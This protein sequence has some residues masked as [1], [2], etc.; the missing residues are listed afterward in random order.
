MKSDEYAPG[1]QEWHFAVA[2]ELKEEAKTLSGEDKQ[3]KQELADFH[4]LIGQNQ[5]KVT[6]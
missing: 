1:S 3:Y 4:R 2:D 6:K 5:P